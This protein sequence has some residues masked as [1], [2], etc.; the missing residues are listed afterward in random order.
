MSDNISL[1]DAFGVKNAEDAQRLTQE[2]AQ[3]F[4][5]EIREIEAAQARGEAVPDYKF[6]GFIK[7]PPILGAG[8]RTLVLPFI[9]TASD[10][11][12]ENAE[13][14][15]KH[16]A[17]KVLSNT[18]HQNIAVRGTS[19]ALGLSVLL[20]E[21]GIEFWNSLST[22]KKNIL[23][24][25]TDIAPVLKEIKGNH[26]FVKFLSVSSDENEVIY[27][28]R[29]KISAAHTN[30]HLINFVNMIDKL[31]KILHFGIKEITKSKIVLPEKFQKATELVSAKANWAGATMSP[32]NSLYADSLKKDFKI[33]N[34]KPSALAMITS[35][36]EQLKQDPEGAD[37]EIP[38]AKNR[39]VSLSDYIMLTFKRHQE[40][41]S[42]LDPS[43]SALR[44]KLDDRLREISEHLATSIRNGEINP[45][46]LIRFVGER[47]IIK[48]GG[49]AL[50]DLKQVD[51]IIQKYSGKTQSYNRVPEKEF[52][53]DFSK[54]DVKTVLS[55]L[56]GEERQMFMATLPDNIL[57]AAGVSAQDIKEM[58]EKTEHT[59]REM[60]AQS[61][62]GLAANDNPSLEAM[63]M[64]EAEIAQ[65]REV[66]QAI[67]THGVQAID[68]FRSNA[69]KADGI[70]HVLH[71]AVTS[72]IMAG[73]AQVLG[74]LTEQG[75]QA[76]LNASANENSPQNFDKE[77]DVDADVDADM[78]EKLSHR[79][80]LHA[81]RQKSAHRALHS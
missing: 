25:A 16:L 54:E 17:P 61:V 38:G 79:E 34:A 60:L 10:Y 56:R 70:E 52:F 59:Y 69:S 76:M 33:K 3:D 50:A 44:T 46:M 19:L 20:A 66:Q 2:R 78:A 13:K 45:L 67:S 14:V 11:V 55:T 63:G 29:Q 32:F 27:A 73:D 77:E 68:H 41:M 9:Y 8:L 31:P 64:A 12:Q 80:K 4:A 71:Q 5:Q 23:S 47:Q 49:R 22:Y 26:G 62:M 75:K 24:S 53:A 43:Y 58:R 28:H 39:Q 1:K 37:L 18:R 40:H 74:K 36:A 57:E 7:L 30:S 72:K 35:L 81:N 15:T 48:N 42:E 6:L 51:H 21:N 65:L